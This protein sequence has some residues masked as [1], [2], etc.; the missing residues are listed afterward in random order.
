MASRARICHSPFDTGASGTSL[1][2]RYFDRFRGERRSWKKRTNKTSGAGGTVSRKVYI[3]PRLKLTV[4]DK[5]ASLKNVTIFPMQMRSELDELY[6]N[7][8]QDVVAKF[9]SFTLDFSSMTLSLGI[10]CQIGPPNEEPEVG[11]FVGFGVCC[12]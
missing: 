8:G 12:L 6:G 11:L 3:Q 10:L 5:T 4:G 1:S 2:V 7:L 9:D